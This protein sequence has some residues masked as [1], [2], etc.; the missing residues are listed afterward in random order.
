MSSFCTVSG[1][2]LSPSLFARTGHGGPAPFVPPKRLVVVG[3]YRHVR[4]PIYVGATAGW[5]GLWIVLG[6]A[7]LKSV[8]IAAAAALSVHSFVVFYEE[9][10]LRKKFDAEYREYCRN[11]RRWWPPVKGWDMLQRSARI[12]AATP[13]S[14]ASQRM[15]S[16]SVMRVGSQ[17]LMI[18]KGECGHEFIKHLGAAGAP[19]SEGRINATS[20]TFSPGW[21]ACAR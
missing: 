15:S 20:N 16:L 13:E 19:A 10:T 17:A 18:C 21:I 9:L 4:N 6:H 1:P 14:M 2:P 3:F 7:N 5:I 8:A 11:V 12:R